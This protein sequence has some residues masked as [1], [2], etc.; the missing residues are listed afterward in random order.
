MYVRDRVFFGGDVNDIT[1]VGGDLA[2][3]ATSDA[4]KE[5]MIVNLADPDNLVEHASLNYPALA[6]GIDFADNKV[7]MAVRSNDALRIITSSP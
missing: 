1:C 5:F 7:F 2:F 6:T 4:N 3:L